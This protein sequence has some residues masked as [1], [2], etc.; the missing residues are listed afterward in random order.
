MYRVFLMEPSGLPRRG[1]RGF[2]GQSRQLHESESEP[3]LTVYANIL[4]KHHLMLAAANGLQQSC[5]Q[6][7]CVARRKL[8]APGTPF[9]PHL[10]RGG[11]RASEKI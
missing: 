3:R 6:L 7:R 1:V 8:E 5:A 11:M 10:M 2:A 4:N 9:D